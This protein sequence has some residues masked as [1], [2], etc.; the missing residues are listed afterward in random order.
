MPAIM[1][2]DDLSYRLLDSSTLKTISVSRHTL[3]GAMVLCFGETRRLRRHLGPVQDRHLVN[4]WARRI[5]RMF[6]GRATC[7]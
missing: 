5:S 3:L 6:R 2:N 7:L 1:L 4:D